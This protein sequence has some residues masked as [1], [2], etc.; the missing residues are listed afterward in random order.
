MI[1]NNDNTLSAEGKK[2]YLLHFLNTYKHLHGIHIK[3]V[4][5]GYELL[6][7]L[8]ANDIVGDGLLEQMTIVE[9]ITFVEG[10]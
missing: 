5:F 10:Q 7:F 6:E 4:D 9:A 8:S 1:P 3:L 2:R